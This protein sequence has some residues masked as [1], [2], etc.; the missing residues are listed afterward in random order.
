[1]QASTM[2]RG[3]CQKCEEVQRAAPS[4]RWQTHTTD[5]LH[6]NPQ[7]PNKLKIVSRLPISLQA[8]RTSEQARLMSA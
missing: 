8:G 1:M 7:L 6:A 2:C 5:E 3:H 4:L